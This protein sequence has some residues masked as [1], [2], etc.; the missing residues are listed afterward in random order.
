[1]AC[2][3]LTLNGINSSCDSSMGGIIEVYG[4][5]A[6]AISGVTLSA[7]T[8]AD[9]VAG[10]GV[11]AVG[12]ASGGTKEYSVSD[13]ALFKFRKNTASLTKTFTKDDANGVQF[14][15]SDLTLMFTRMDAAKRAEL[16]ALAK[17][18]AKFIVKDAN[19]HY[20]FLGLDEGVVVEELTG[21]TGQQRTDGNYYQVV[22]RDTAKEL[23]YEVDK[24]F[25]ETIAAAVD[26]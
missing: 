25:A 1:M 8:F 17:G 21:Q 24:A 7:A 16:V 13:W 11:T 19:G 15:Q 6:E 18:E 2:N 14:V 26:A 12:Y 23:P 4:I 9:A 10:T 3:S 5:P 20:W 22:L